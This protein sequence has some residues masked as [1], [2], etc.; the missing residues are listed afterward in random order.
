MEK[1]YYE[2]CHGGYPFK[3]IDNK[4]YCLGHTDLKDDPKIRYECVSCPKY[5]R[6]N[7]GNIKEY[8]ERAKMIS[9]NKNV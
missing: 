6:N 9:D 2:K 1:I 7:L 3:E 4:I 8:V 5:L